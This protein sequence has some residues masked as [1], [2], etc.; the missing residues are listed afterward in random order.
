MLQES[1]SLQIED[2][3][4][5]TGTRFGD[6]RRTVLLLHGQRF[7]QTSWHDVAQELAEAGLAAVTLDFRGYGLSSPL[8]KTASHDL[9]VVRVVEGLRAEGAEEVCLLGGS[10][11]GAA[12]LRAAALHGARVDR[13]ATVSPAVDATEV[14]QRLPPVP[15]LLLASRDE[16]YVDLVAFRELSRHPLAIHLYPGDAHNQALLRGPHGEDVRRRLKDFL[17]EGL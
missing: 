3:G 16:P 10:M 13:I 9:D 5:L 15:M 2:G 1:W 7:D 11:G 8:P 17:T 4:R 12:A 6:G 14:A